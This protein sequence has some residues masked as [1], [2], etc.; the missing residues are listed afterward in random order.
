[1]LFRSGAAGF[2]ALALFPTIFPLGLAVFY[3]ETAVQ[4][5]KVSE[6]VAAKHGGWILAIIFLLIGLDFLH[7]ALG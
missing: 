6:A 2:L 7:G 3:P 5:R 4:A 1:M